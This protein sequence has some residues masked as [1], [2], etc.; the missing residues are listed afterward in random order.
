[1]NVFEDRG[2]IRDI[3]KLQDDPSKDVYE[4]AEQFMGRLDKLKQNEAK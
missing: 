4:R 3:Q 1:M 2:I